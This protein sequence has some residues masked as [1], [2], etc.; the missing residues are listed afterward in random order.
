MDAAEQ[1]TVDGV[2]AEVLLKR[3][4]VGSALQSSIAG[5]EMGGD[6]ERK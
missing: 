2:G 3:P 4:A 5:T 6:R 1:D